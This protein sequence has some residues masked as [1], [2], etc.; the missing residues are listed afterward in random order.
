MNFF[1]EI[2]LI[3]VSF[4]LVQP[5]KNTHLKLH[6]FFSIL[7]H[8]LVYILQLLWEYFTYRPKKYPLSEIVKRFHVKCTK[9]CV[10]FTAPRQC[11]VCG[12]LA[13]FECGECF[14]EHGEGL[15]STAFCETCLARVH[16]NPK[17]RKHKMNQLKV[18][19]EYLAQG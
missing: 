1:K 8:F 12:K 7:E 5:T 9:N 13:G 4:G 14:G 3:L 11:I 19:Q 2:P 6:L 18:P 17:R 10:L 15:D 16:N